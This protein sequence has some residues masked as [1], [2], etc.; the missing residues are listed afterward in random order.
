MSFDYRKYLRMD[1][2]PHI[3]CPGCG[4][5]IVLKAMIRAFDKLKIEKNDLCVASGIG[6][7][8]RIPG[9][10]DAN[11][12]HTAHGRALPF[13]IGVK[14]VKPK[15]NVVVVSG[16]GD[17]VAIGGNHFIHA[18]RR[19]IDITLIVFNNYIY[20][21]TG[22]QFSPTTPTFAIATTS[23]YGNLEPGF[24]IVK[25]AMGS[26]ATFV[27]RTT[28]YHVMEMEKLFVQAIEHK[29][30][31]VVEVLV[32]CPSNYGRR[33]KLRT[34]VD[35]MKWQKENAVS[36]AKA[37]KMSPEELKGKIVT[38]VFLEEEREEYV[39]RYSRLSEMAMKS[40]N[41]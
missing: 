34:G 19:N 4:D 15:M 35:L 24:D 1:K 36:R 29:G 10:V 8:S 18:C 28:S 16:D 27:A 32:G 22:G 40:A 6:C 31:S 25:L 38:G 17:A 41:L 20:G 12:L 26:G 5:G 37:E 30:F 23:P 2:F 9:Y 33:N 11:T 7:A 14:M 3:L 13:A 21:M 39:H